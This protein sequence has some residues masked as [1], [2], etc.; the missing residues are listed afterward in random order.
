M[1]MSKRKIHLFQDKIFQFYKEH[2]R[3]LPWRNT[4]DPHHILISEIML[5]QTQV[6]RVVSY[7]TQWVTRWPTLSDLAHTSYGDVLRMWMGLGYNRRAQYL[8]QTAKI[9]DHDFDGDLLFALQQQHKLPGIGPYTSKAVQIFATNAD[10]AAVD[11][12]I[13]RIYIHELHLPETLSDSEVCS[14]AEQCL[15]KGRSREWHNALMDYGALSLTAAKTGI[16]PKTRQSK[17]EGSDRQVRA[18]ILR[19]LLQHPFAFAEL[20]QMLH[21]NQARL[22]QILTKMANEDV[23]TCTDA[24][25][26]IPSL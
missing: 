19:T 4:T 25:Y 17:F 22:E 8:H 3:T 11:T 7:Y 10:L 9:I 1:N 20:Q 13:R 14:Y 12:N 18:T 21:I 24:V 16:K 23:I 5:Q 26:Q 2:G 15:P 6:S